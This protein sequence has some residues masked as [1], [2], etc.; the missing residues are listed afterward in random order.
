MW[1]SRLVVLRMVLIANREINVSW[2]ETLETCGKLGS[3]VSATKIFL[4]ICLELK[5]KTR[6]H[7]SKYH[8]KYH[9]KYNI[10]GT[11]FAS[12]PRACESSLMTE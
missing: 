5:R 7:D 3:I 2:A 4:R 1:V 8:S 12:L 10:S 11:M 9:S 6:K